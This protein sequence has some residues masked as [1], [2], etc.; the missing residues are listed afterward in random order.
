MTTSGD[1]RGELRGTYERRQ[2]EAG[3]YLLRN[4]VTGRVLVGSSPDLRSMRNRLEFGQATN[5]PGVLDRRMVDDAREHGMAA[6]EFEVAD[7]L[8]TT[9]GMSEAEVAADLDQLAAL[10]REKLADVPQ[11]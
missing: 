3:V 11:Y 10:W 9:P 4:S 8:E 7:V 2:A 1:R 6:F 5:S